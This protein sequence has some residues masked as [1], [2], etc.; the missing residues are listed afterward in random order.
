[1]KVQRFQPNAR[2]FV[3]EDDG[4]TRE[5]TDAEFRAYLLECL[6]DPDRRGLVSEPEPSS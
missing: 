3:T 2:G 5:E 6:A 1:M 4:T